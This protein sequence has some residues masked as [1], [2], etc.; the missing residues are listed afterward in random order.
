MRVGAILAALLAGLLGSSLL[1]QG[2]PAAWLSNRL[3]AEFSQDSTIMELR[4]EG[5]PVDRTS[6]SDDAQLMA[7]VMQA[8]QA[9]LNDP[10]PWFA[11]RKLSEAAVHVIQTPLITER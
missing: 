3:Q 4:L 5:S 6:A 11:A 8:Y 7:A 2:D 10:P 1:A 9:A